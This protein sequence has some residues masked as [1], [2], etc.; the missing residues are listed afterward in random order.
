MFPFTLGQRLEFVKTR[1][2]LRSLI[3]KGTRE[4]TRGFRRG[5]TNVVLLSHVVL[6]KLIIEINGLREEDV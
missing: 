2:I 4:E 5:C 6:I 1:S 3:Q